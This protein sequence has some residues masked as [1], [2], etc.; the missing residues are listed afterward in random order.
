M[1]GFRPSRRHALRWMGAAAA[2]GMLGSAIRPGLQAAEGVEADDDR[3]IVD[4]HIHVVSSRPAR[5]GGKLPAPF[6]LAE[7]PDGPERLGR[8][9][10]DELKGAGVGHALVMPGID[11]T[12]DD[13]L[14][15]NAPMKQARYVR[16]VKLHPFCVE[17][18]EHNKR[19]HKTQDEAVFKQGKAKALKAYLGYVHRDPTDLGYRPYYQLAGK[20]DIPV[21]FHT[22]D[23]YSPKAKLKFAH[24]LLIDEL[25]VDFPETKFVLAHFGNP[26]LMDAAQVVYKN[27]NVWADLSGILIGDAERFAAMI[28]DGM[29]PRTVT[30]VKEAIEY[31]ESPE[32]FVFGSDWPLAPVATYRD[33]VRQLFPPEQHAAVFGGNARALF[34]L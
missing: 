30:R 11:V 9:I 4:T 32:K 3:S 26:W 24:P 16:G 33:F 17:Q 14:G 31:A 15:I 29:L 13:P 5:G 10:E 2:G 34:R 12:A 18:P 6:D 25:A 20:Y 23:T 19:T 7:Q 28:A 1:R 8:V 27:H 22:G 21:I